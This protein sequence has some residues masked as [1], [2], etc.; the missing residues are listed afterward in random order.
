MKVFR[1]VTDSVVMEIMASDRD[2]AARLFARSEGFT[3]IETYRQLYA[4]IYGQ[5]GWIRLI[6]I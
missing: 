4:R 5:N 1:V 3:G 6:E 2:H